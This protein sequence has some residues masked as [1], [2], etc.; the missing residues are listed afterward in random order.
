MIHACTHILHHAFAC[1]FLKITLDWVGFI[2]FSKTP[3]DLKKFPKRAFPYTDRFCASGQQVLLVEDIQPKVQHEKMISLQ[4]LRQ[5]CDLF[6]AS[7]VRRIEMKATCFF[8]RMILFQLCCT[9]EMFIQ[10]EEMRINE[11]GL[12]IE[13]FGFLIPLFYYDL[14]EMD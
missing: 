13:V 9:D 7:N 12:Q 14:I 3:P 1:V 6:H 10:R 11:V 4:E 2:N 5:E 8:R